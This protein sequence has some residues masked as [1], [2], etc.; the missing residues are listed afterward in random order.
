VN[1]CRQGSVVACRLGSVGDPAGSVVRGTG[2][3]RRAWAHQ[4]ATLGV[5]PLGTAAGDLE[6]IRAPW[7][8]QGEGSRAAV[9]GEQGHWEAHASAHEA[10]E[11]PEVRGVVG[12]ED[13]WGHVEDSREGHEGRR[14]GVASA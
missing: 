8:I 5:H 2:G 11:A 6:R 1:A 13:G 7:A 10:R 14:S 3:D 12:H 4:R 9:L